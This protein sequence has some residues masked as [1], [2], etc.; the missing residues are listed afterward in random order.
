MTHLAGI[1]NVVGL[2][3]NMVGVVVLFFFG[4]PQPTHD[5][6]VG[7][8]L[9]DA[10]RLANGMTVAEHNASIRRRRVFYKICSTVGLGLLFVGFLLQLPAAIW[11]I[12]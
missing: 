6:G 5:E 1:L 3:A 10:T 9:Q 2:G 8:G 4:F 7:L 12:A 11:A